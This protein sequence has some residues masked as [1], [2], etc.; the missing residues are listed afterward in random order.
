MVILDKLILPY[1]AKVLPIFFRGI[2]IDKIMLIQ[3]KAKRITI[4][5]LSYLSFKDYINV[6]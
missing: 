6:I 5:N 1:I 2:V 3:K 4:R